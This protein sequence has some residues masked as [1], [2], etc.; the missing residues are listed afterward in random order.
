MKLQTHKNKT[1]YT[2]CACYDKGQVKMIYNRRNQ[3]WTVQRLES[4]KSVEYQVVKTSYMAKKYFR[5]FW[6]N[7]ITG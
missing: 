1:T 6:N 4:M 5:I 7:T 3:N 2:I